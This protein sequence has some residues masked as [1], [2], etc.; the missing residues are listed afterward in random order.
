MPSICA[1]SGREGIAPF[2]KEA[3]ELVEINSVAYLEIVH[4]SAWAKHKTSKSTC[5]LKHKPKQPKKVLALT[6]KKENGEN[7][8]TLLIFS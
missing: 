6:V 2:T 5:F 8:L 3:Q 7:S 1:K 4:I